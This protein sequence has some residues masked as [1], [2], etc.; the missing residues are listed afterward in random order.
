ADLRK[1]TAA[2]MPYEDASFDVAFA[3]HMLYLVPDVRAAIAEQRR[4][5]R[6]GGRLYAATNGT[7]HVRELHEELDRLLELLPEL[8]AERVNPQR[9]ALDTGRA[10]LESYFEEVRVFERRDA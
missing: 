1:H 3:N 9:F 10:L 7:H 2:D 4:V 6:P 8:E 5:L